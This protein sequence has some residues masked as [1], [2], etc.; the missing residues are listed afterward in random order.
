M[1]SLGLFAVNRAEAGTTQV[2]DVPIEPLADPQQTLSSYVREHYPQSDEGWSIVLNDPDLMKDR[3]FVVV[4]GN[5]RL[6]ALRMISGD[7][8]MK[9]AWDIDAL[10]V[11][12]AV[13]EIS[14]VHKLMSMG[15]LLNKIRGIQ[16]TDQFYD[17]IQSIVYQAR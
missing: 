9:C 8:L 7:D 11:R 3:V 4:D 1:T 12:V 16:A 17:R 13:L 5:H 14:S 2:D 15:G 10:K 6:A